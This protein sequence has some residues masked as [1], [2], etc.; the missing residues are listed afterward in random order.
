MKEVFVDPTVVSP[1]E[2]TLNEMSEITGGVAPGVVIWVTSCG[3]PLAGG[4]ALAVVTV[5]EKLP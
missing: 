1:R 4:V 3:E 2:L 5:V